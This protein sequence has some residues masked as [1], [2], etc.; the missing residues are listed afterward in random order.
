MPPHIYAVIRTVAELFWQIR[1]PEK[2]P[3]PLAHRTAQIW[4]FPAP[5][6]KEEFSAP[7]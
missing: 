5:R 7:A 3:N 4:R 1:K 2:Q 6:W